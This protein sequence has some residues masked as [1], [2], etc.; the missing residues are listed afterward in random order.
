MFVVL[1]FPLSQHAAFSLY[2]QNVLRDEWNPA[3]SLHNVM[4]AIQVL[5]SSVYEDEIS[6]MALN[7]AAY[8]LYQTHRADFEQTARYYTQVFAHPNEV[9]HVCDLLGFTDRDLVKSVLEESE[10][11]E[12]GAV[13]RFM[14]MDEI[15]T[16]SNSAAA[17]ESAKKKARVEENDKNKPEESIVTGNTVHTLGSVVG[18]MKQAVLDGGDEAPRTQK[19]QREEK[20]AAEKS[21][22]SFLHFSS[23]TTSFVRPVAEVKFD[24]VGNEGKEE[25]D[26][27]GGWTQESYVHVGGSEGSVVCRMKE[28]KLDSDNEASSAHDSF[29]WVPSVAED[30]KQVG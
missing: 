29:V 13:M 24:I 18:R 7:N 23:T 15:T 4:L 19:R 9:T 26:S 14:S 2:L 10:W 17:F 22:D 20:S 12:A 11:D 16:E 8:Q 30:K 28:V 21:L 6:E 27:L 1:F 25:D 5:L 3:W